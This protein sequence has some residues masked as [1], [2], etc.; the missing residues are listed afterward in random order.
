M[1]RNWLLPPSLQFALRILSGKANR[2]HTMQFL[3]GAVGWTVPT[4]LQSAL[5]SVA[6]AFRGVDASRNTEL[7]LR[8]QG[9]RCFVLGNGPSLK[10]ADLALLR[11]EI[12]IGANSFFQHPQAREI[13]LKYLCIGDANFFDDTAKGVAWHRLIE[14]T[15]P[16]TVMMFN[17]AAKALLQRHG[18]YRG[19]Q[20]FYYQQGITVTNPDLVHFDF[21]KPLNVGHNTGSRLSIPLA[22]YMGC[23][24]II[25][26]GYDCNW[27]EN[28]RG[29][30]HFY[31]RNPH[32]PEFDSQAAD[33][34]WPRYADQL[35]NALRDFESHALLAEAAGAMGVKIVNASGGLLDTYPRISYAEAL[36]K[37]E[38]RA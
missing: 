11:D 19:H 27:M 14:E 32:F 36:G 38:L 22:V 9:R 16:H 12:T 18:L 20:V 24:Q 13:Q 6:Y 34:R 30:Y 1:M 10:D 37:A 8:H 21:T 3:R 2:A 7:K 23:A 31:A 33:G 28:F 4:E 15:L 25:L 17:P 5:L 26:L 29:S 35:L